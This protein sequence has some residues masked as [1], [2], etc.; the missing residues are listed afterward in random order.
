MP[1]GYTASVADG[2]VTDLATFAMQLARGMGACITMRDA[3]SDAPIPEKFEPHDYHA[4]RLEEA[5][6]ELERLYAMSEDEAQSEADKEYAEFLADRDRAEGRHATQRSNYEAM[7][8]N[9][10]AWTGA[11]EGIKEFA[12][13]QL[14]TG[15]DFDCRGPF[16][17]WR[18][19]PPEIGTEWRRAKLEKAQKDVEY[20]TIEDAKERTRTEGRN[21]WLAQLRASLKATPGEA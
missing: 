5:R 4:K 6:T 15:M 21:A 14:R 18:E 8:A 9:V 3:P 17:Y 7:I 16:S 1:T 10:E 13:E 19:G 20:H 12:L 11:P 2:T